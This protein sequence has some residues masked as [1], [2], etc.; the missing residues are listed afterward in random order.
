MKFSLFCFI[1]QEFSEEKSVLYNKRSKFQSILVFKSA[2]YGK[3]G[4]DCAPCCFCLF[5]PSHTALHI[6]GNV[7]VLD[8]VLQ[9][10][11]RDEFA[12]HEMMSHLPLCSHPNPKTVLI[13]G[14][15]DGGIL[16]QVCRHDSVQQITMVEI[17]T[18]VIEVAKLYFTK[19][20]AVAFDDS[21]LTIV[22]VD[23]FEYMQSS[24]E[25][26]DVI[27]ADALDPIG[28]GETIFT[29]DFYELM[30]KALNPG[31]VVCVQ[32]E[33][34]WVNLDL[35]S[36][37]VHCCNDIFDYAEYATAN[38][39]SFPCGQTGFVL[40]R[41]GSNASCRKPVRRPKFASQLKYYNACVHE[42]SF[43][44]P[45]FVKRRLGIQEDDDGED[46]LLNGGCTL[47]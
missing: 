13:V 11:E 41:K 16:K 1:S 45:E 4:T 46:C 26:F 43:Q 3:E 10:T 5:D 39:P 20:T 2:Q 24:T 7:L 28:P 38:I 12:Y 6:T 37:V 33:C 32:S 36:D 15:G 23:G 34:W 21:R 22:N 8:G 44:L 31:G 35:I 47:Q 40:A 30:Y 19:S 27:I 42:A 14:G 29:P 25:K 18:Q 17:D 9:L